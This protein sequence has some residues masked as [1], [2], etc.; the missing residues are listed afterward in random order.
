MMDIEQ[1]ADSIMKGAYKNALKEELSPCFFIVDPTGAMTCMAVPH[2]GNN[3]DAHIAMLRFEIEKQNA[4]FYMVVMEAWMSRPKDTPGEAVRAVNRPLVRP[5]DDPDRIS[6]IVI[7]GKH[8]DGREVY[9]MAEIIEPKGGG[10]KGR[11]FK[12]LPTSE[13]GHTLSIFDNMF[14]ELGKPS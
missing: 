9:R 8:R 5:R 14:G 11:K 6:A 1:T 2:Y 13:I 10:F 3:K 4:D 7:Y 12:P